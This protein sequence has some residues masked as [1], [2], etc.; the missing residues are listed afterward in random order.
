MKRSIEVQA[1]LTT[2][3]TMSYILFVQPALL[4]GQFLGQPTGMDFSALATATCLVCALT[5]LLMGLY[6]RLPIA[7]GPGMGESFFFLTSLLPAVTALGGNWRTALGLIFFTGLLLFLL[8][9]L[10]WSRR[11]VQSFS[12]SLRAAL[13]IGIGLFITRIGLQNAGLLL[14]DPTTGFRLSPTLFSLESLYFFSALLFGAYLHIRKISSYI[15]WAILSSFILHLLFSSRLSLSWPTSLFSLPPSPG[16]LWLELDF[17]ALSSF[18]LL[19]LVFCLLILNLFDSTGTLYAVSR[20]AGLMKNEQPHR[21]QQ[22]LTAT[23]LGSMISPLF[24]LTS[25]TGY[26]ESLAGVEQGGRTGQTSLVVALLFLLSLFLYP[27]ISMIAQAP[28]LTAPA[29]VLVG[30]AMMKWVTRIEWED[31]TE[32]LPSFLVILC[33]P[34]TFSIASG[35]G[36]GLICYPFLKL[37]AGRR[38]EINPVNL[39]LAASFLLF[40]WLQ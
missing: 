1:G 22:A 25:V 30:I 34:L 4:S 17:T 35:I 15:L 14:K 31:Y 13:I 16:S 5:T 20:Q 7:V 11:I 10:G 8:S 3:L 28:A 2:F 37:L 9:V 19:P 6:G 33:V 21:H 36:I 29:L 39:L 24:G 38:K 27:W 18:S 23:A 32:A 26:L 40:F 12:P